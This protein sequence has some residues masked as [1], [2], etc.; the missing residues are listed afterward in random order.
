MNYNLTVSDCEVASA[1]V[2]VANITSTGGCNKA[3]GSQTGLA[4][5]QDRPDQRPVPLLPSSAHQSPH[6][7]NT[8]VTHQ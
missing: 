5:W 4:G 7:S 1:V 8:A 3:A 2:N 6:S